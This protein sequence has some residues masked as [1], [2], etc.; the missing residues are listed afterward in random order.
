[1]SWILDVI[2]FVVLFLGT[3]IGAKIG[4]I[5]GVCKTAGWVLSFVIPFIF[6]F[7]FKDTLESWF[8]LESLIS[9][10]IGNA[11][12]GGWITV[13][14]SFVILFIIVK[15][16]TWLIGLAG[17]ALADSVKAVSVINHILGAVLGL[18]EAAALVLFLLL[19][20]HWLPMDNVHAFI[21]DSFVVGAIYRSDLM[22]LLPGFGG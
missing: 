7:A 1:M 6:C 5:R 11:T 15:L 3:L 2:F 13:V 16:G 14:I 17:G 21:N 9:D 8:G 12:L 18:L 10:G 4:F 22:A 20:C 19:V